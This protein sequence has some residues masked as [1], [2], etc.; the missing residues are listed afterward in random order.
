MNKEQ[1]NI[2]PRWVT[3]EKC[4]V[5]ILSDEPKPTCKLCGSNLITIVKPLLENINDSK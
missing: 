2:K 1:Y 4:Q 5:T 3:C